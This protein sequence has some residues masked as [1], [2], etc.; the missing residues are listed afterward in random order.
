MERPAVSCARTAGPRRFPGARMPPPL[1]SFRPPPPR[2]SGDSRNPRPFPGARMPP[3]FPYAAPLTR[4]SGE[5]RN[6]RC[7]PTP[8][9]SASTSDGGQL[10]RWPKCGRDVDPGFRR[11]DGVGPV[12]PP[13]LPYAAQPTRHSGESRK[14][15]RP[16]TPKDSAST[17]DDGQLLRWPKRGGDVDPGFRRGDGVG[18][19]CPPPF[20]ALVVALD[21][22]LNDPVNDR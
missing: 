5:S 12:C 10:L 16:P 19:V 15:R 18:P 20:P 8:K 21:A 6:L 22:I 13:P 17:S 3:P 4:H 2:L 1:P 7:S 9:D 11:G 14:P